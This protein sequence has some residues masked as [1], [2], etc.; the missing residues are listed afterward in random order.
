MTSE[1]ATQTEIGVRPATADDWPA[2]AALLAEL[3]RPDVLGGPDEE[4]A[5]RVF[6][7]YLQRDDAVALLAVDGDRVVGFVDM[8]FRPRLNFTTPQA[9]IPD[10]IVSE[11]E[12]SRGAGAA[13]IAR[14]EEL[15]RDRDCWSISLE[16]A[17]WRDRAHGFYLREGFAD[18]AKSFSKLLAPMDWPPSPR[19]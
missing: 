19:S 11:T 16:S 18:S 2:V 14:C 9:W 12:R 8:E 4:A 13:L 1:E 3:G 17:N 10:L 7:D 5:H 15:A 6:L